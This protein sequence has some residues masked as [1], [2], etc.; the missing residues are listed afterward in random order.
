MQFQS[1]IGEKK[2]KKREAFYVIHFL[3]Q[4]AFMQTKFVRILWR[5]LLKLV[6]TIN[7]G[8]SSHTKYDFEHWKQQTTIGNFNFCCMYYGQNKIMPWI[9][10][11]GTINLT[12]WPN[13]IWLERQANK[14]NQYILSSWT[15]KNKI[16]GMSSRTRC[17]QIA[18]GRY[19][20]V[21]PKKEEASGWQGQ[22]IKVFTCWAFTWHQA[23]KGGRTK[24]CRSSSSPRAEQRC[25]LFLQSQRTP[26]CSWRHGRRSKDSPL[27]PLPTRV[28]IIFL[29]SFSVSPTV[30]VVFLIVSFPAFLCLSP[31][32]RM[33]PVPLIKDDY[34]SYD[35]DEGTIPADPYAYMPQ[36]DPTQSYLADPPSVVW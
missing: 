9:I 3:L 31:T 22:K 17:F 25:L 16:A 6:N 26:R 10:R 2:E 23:T 20:S 28:H 21:G 33:T 7:L 27:S 14:P 30:P 8:W 12:S 32:S 1:L 11:N 24:D 29:I 35:S 15:E 34:S 4:K 5:S 19:A 18:G 36:W 13:I